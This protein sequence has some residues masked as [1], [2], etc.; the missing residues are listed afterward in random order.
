MFGA[1]AEHAMR[2]AHAE[3]AKA[4]TAVFMSSATKARAATCM[5]TARGTFKFCRSKTPGLADAQIDAHVIGADTF[6]E[7]NKVR[8]A[9]CRHNRIEIQQPVRRIDRIRTRGAGKRGTDGHANF[10]LQKQIISRGEVKGLSAVHDDKRRKAQAP[11]SRDRAAQEEVVFDVL[12]RP[13]PRSE[14]HTSE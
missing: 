11:W 5:G 10:P 3:A 6:I 14:E 7:R 8:C 2:T 13:A 9:R 4:A 1:L 12:R